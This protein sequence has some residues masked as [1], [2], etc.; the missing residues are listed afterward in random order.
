MADRP[1]W[2]QSEVK[3]ALA[4]Y[5]VTDFGRFHSRNP[6]VIRLGVQLDRTASAVALKLTNLAA[7][8]DSLMQR[9]MVNASATDRLV[10]AER[11]QE[12]REV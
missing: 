8:D 4:L 9:G 2:T 5:L 10:W 7:L 11:W 1:N 6:D 12:F 3:E